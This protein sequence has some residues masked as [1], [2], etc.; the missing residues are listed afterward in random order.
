VRLLSTNLIS[1]G[2]KNQLL[3]QIL[4]KKVLG[5][6]CSAKCP[7]KVLLFKILI[8]MLF[9]NKKFCLESLRVFNSHPLVI[10]YTN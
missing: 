3:M 2:R 8:L 9:G 6:G 10:R 4:P 5:E 1:E 7:K